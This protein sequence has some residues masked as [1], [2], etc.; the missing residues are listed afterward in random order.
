MP[1]TSSK[2]TPTRYRMYAEVAAAVQPAKK[3]AARLRRRIGRFEIYDLLGA[4]YRVHVDWKRRKIAK[5]SARILADRLAIARRKGM[6]PA[7]VL[8]EAT[9]PE[10]DFKQK[11]RWVR[12]LDYLS[13]ENIQ[14]RDFHKFVSANGGLAGCARLAAQTNRKRRRPGGDWGDD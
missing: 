5:Q 12:A 7:R 14:P 1:A 6:S 3:A 11:S 10:A 4:I 2:R 13:S 8:I 9:L